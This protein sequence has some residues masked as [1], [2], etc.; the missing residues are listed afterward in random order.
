MCV[1]FSDIGAKLPHVASTTRN[2]IVYKTLSFIIFSSSLLAIMHV[3][4]RNSF[5]ISLYFRNIL[6]LMLAHNNLNET[7]S[8]PSL[9]NKISFLE[10]IKRKQEW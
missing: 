6:F 9:F 2:E 5:S 4:V 7:H 10:K 1:E 3:I 8:L